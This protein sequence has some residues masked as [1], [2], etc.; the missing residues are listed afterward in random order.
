MF[1]HERNVLKIMSISCDIKEENEWHKSLRR[2]TI[3]VNVPCL[4]TYNVSH[5]DWYWKPL[6]SYT[7]DLC[8]WNKYGTRNYN[9]L[10]HNKYARESFRESGPSTVMWTLTFT[11]I[12]VQTKRSW[13]NKLE[14]IK[15][16]SVKLHVLMS[17]F[18]QQGK[19][20]SSR[21]DFLV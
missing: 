17:K 4:F 10:W 7:F 15:T 11:F 3:R 19:K 6:K 21:N 2:I 8:G 9:V 12:L 13:R 14:D 1:F 5:F 20:E 18:R 16:V